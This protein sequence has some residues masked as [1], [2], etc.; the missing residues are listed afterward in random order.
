MYDMS[1]TITVRTT[2]A[3]RKALERRARSLGKTAS[4]FVRETLE[5][6]LAERPLGDRAGHVKGRLELAQPSEEWRQQIE[7][8]NWRR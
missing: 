2:A 5:D 8:R 4:E 6:A 3:L 1:T 7:E